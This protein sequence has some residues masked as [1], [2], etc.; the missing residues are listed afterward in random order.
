[1]NKGKRGI[2]IRSA[3]FRRR[4]IRQ[5]EPRE[6]RETKARTTRRSAGYVLAQLHG[7]GTSCPA[8]GRSAGIWSPRRLPSSCWRSSPKRRRVTPELSHR[9]DTHA[10]NVQGGA[11]PSGS[12]RTKIKKKKQI[13]GEKGT[14]DSLSLLNSLARSLSLARSGFFLSGR[15]NTAGEPTPE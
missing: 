7:D 9:T 13:L 1:M 2:P 10:H 12:T 3:R 15:N 4:P 8:R 5:Q 6:C 14:C 11:P